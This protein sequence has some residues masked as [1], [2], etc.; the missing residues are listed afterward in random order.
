MPRL[1]LCEYNG[2]VEVNTGYAFGEG[3]LTLPNGATE[4]A[5]WLNNKKHGFCSFTNENGE[6]LEGEV[7]NGEWK[8]ELTVYW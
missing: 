3:I 8:G 5:T 2:E 7:K 6:K 1:G 4:K